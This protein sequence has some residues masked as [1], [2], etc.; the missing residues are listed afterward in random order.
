MDLNGRK[1]AIP[2]G[3]FG[4]LCGVLVCLQ[5]CAGSEKVPEGPSVEKGT[6]TFVEQ[7]SGDYPALEELRETD[8]EGA[9]NPAGEM[10]EVY[11]SAMVKVRAGN[12]SGS[13][14]II[15]SD[16]KYLWIATATHVL[17]QLSQGDSVKVTFAD[18]WEVRTQKVEN[19]ES[20]DLS[21]L[22][23]NREALVEQS[24]GT[25]RD[26]G[27][28]YRRAV[29]SQEAFDSARPGD[30]VISMGSRSGAGEDA[31][32]GVILQDYVYL[33]DF[34]AYMILAEV[35]VTPGMSGGGLFDSRG[36]LLG[37]L[38]GVS[39]DGEVAVCPILSLLTME[40]K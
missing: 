6:I 35:A 32:A 18:G 27:Q 37:I 29:L 15:A 10:Q 17:E 36:R 20:Q 28:E 40:L 1:K 33:E 8:V 12:L 19:S 26:H 23:V 30:L 2:R 5:G 7:V 13:G 24:E 9:D 21:I 3:I 11:A 31:Y 4:L 25:F 39:E 16:Q 34:N 22:R 38:C 14:V